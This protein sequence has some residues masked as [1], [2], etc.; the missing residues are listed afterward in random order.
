MAFKKSLFITSLFI[1]Q[2]TL[3]NFLEVLSSPAE[4]YE[5]KE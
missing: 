2:K 3:E 4:N 1:K 5:I